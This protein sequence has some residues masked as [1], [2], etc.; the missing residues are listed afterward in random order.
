MMGP[1]PIGTSPNMASPKIGQGQPSQAYIQGQ[2]PPT[3]G[4]QQYMSGGMRFPPRMH[5]DMS[6]PGP[7]QQ[8][9]MPPGHP[10]SPTGPGGMMR[11]RPPHFDMS[12]LPRPPRGMPPQQMMGGDGMPMRPRMP[13]QFMSPQHPGM[14]DMPMTSHPMPVSPMGMQT[15]PHAMQS[16]P[17]GMQT[18]P[19]GL[20]SSPHG[21]QTSPHGMPP[22]PPMMSPHHQQMMQQ[23][24]GAGPM[25]PSSY[26]AQ[27]SMSGGGGGGPLASLANFHPPGHMHSVNTSMGAPMPPHPGHPHHMQRPG[28]F[29]PQMMGGAARLRMMAQG[30]PEGGMGGPHFRHQVMMR[31][32]APHGSQPSQMSPSPQMSPHMSPQMSPNMGTQPLHHLDAMPDEKGYIGSSGMSGP[33][34]GMDP[35]MAM[36]GKPK[37]QR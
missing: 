2:Q 20:Q 23:Q 12:R 11:Q 19:H 16:S 31:G 29:P 5:H 32:M 4:Q 15:S 25:P 26:P 33:G 27:T 30:G 6:G 13:P 17:L 18:S 3:Q 36:G 8:Y 10:M 28:M 1:R 34:M 9:A 35:S 24:Q 37:M 7:G 21:M 14:P 22:R